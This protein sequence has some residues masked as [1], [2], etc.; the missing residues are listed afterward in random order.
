MDD[1]AR[2]TW[3][4][5]ELIVLVRGNAEE[6]VLTSCKKASSEQDSAAGYG[7]CGVP[8]S[9]DCGACALLVSS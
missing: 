5:P 2:K 6:A 1:A 4:R 7:G 3:S 8:G 9:G